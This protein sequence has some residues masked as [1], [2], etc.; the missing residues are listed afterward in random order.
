MMMPYRKLRQSFLLIL[1]VFFLGGCVLEIK[2]PL[3]FPDSS[4]VP[5]ISGRYGPPDHRDALVIE[6][7]TGENGKAG[8]HYRLRLSDGRKKDIDMEMVIEPLGEQRY[9]AQLRVDESPR[10]G[11]VAYFLLLAEIELPR[12]TW[13]TLRRH[14]VLVETGKKYGVIIDNAGVVTRYRSLAE[15]KTFLNQLLDDDDKEGRRVLKAEI[16]IREDG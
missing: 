1:V 6:R 13:Y 15:L 4:N 2:E 12:I 5:D 11:K 10:Q 3:F 14:G 7:L 9:I 16:L 8:N